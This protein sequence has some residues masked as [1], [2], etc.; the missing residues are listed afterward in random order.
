MEER[1]ERYPGI[2]PK[3]KRRGDAQ[4]EWAFSVKDHWRWVEPTVWTERMLK[5]LEEGVKGGKWHSL[6]DKVYSER[7]LRAAFER[8]KRNKGSAGV[9]HVRVEAF[10]KRLDANIEKLQRVLKD[11]TYHPQ[12]V[13]RSWIPK[14]GSKEKRPLG[15]PTVRDRVVQTA[16]RNV[17]EPIYERDF[18][19]HSYGFRPNRSCKDALRCVNE[20]LDAGYT[21]VV[22]ADIQGY[23]DAISHE[24]LMA[25][26]WKK[27]ADRR[28]REL[29][30]CFLDQDV[31]DG[32]KHWTPE[33]GTPQGAVISPLLSNIYLDTLDH[34]MA[35]QGIEMVRYA[36]DLV[37]LCR[38]E[39]N[40][41][42]ALELLQGWM[43]QAAL[44]LH[45]EK[46]R[47][48]DHGAGEGFT[49]LGYE[50]QRGR[51][52]VSKKSMKGI[53]SK[54][55]AKTRRTPGMSLER[56]IGELNP[57]LRGWFEYYQHSRPRSLQKVDGYTRMRLRSILRKFNHG[58][59]VG[60]GLDHVRWPNA[61]FT[62]NGLFCLE[63][64]HTQTLQSSRR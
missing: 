20:L 43:A 44:Q 40:A 54:I 33:S 15:V 1:K 24:R 5:A 47:V 17:L 57:I 50:F 34:H 19:E 25:L 10:E 21:H 45:P 42:H 16:L 49:F 46:T 61:Y 53:R 31:M 58:R 29:V 13:K 48:V 26:V 22:D 38:S 6:I 32:L 9:D 64:A 52:W 30:Q 41:E 35:S 62:A 56:I 27:V 18:A 3:A 55:R 11:G 39:A 4:G 28:I 37:L 23:F 60:R 7:N 51:H 36:D 2:V 59:G 14:P 8:V 63:Q 12:A